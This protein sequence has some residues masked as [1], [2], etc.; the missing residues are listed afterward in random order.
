MS[1]R[2]EEYRALRETIATR[3]T[4]RMVLVPAA[5]FGWALL[6][7]GL[8]VFAR[9]PLLSVLSLLALAAAFE[10]VHALHVGVERIG[11]FIQVFYE[12][13]SAGPR[14]ESTAMRLGPGLPGSG[15]DPLFTLL[16]VGAICAN[17]LVVF[18]PSPSVAQ[19]TLLLL[20]HGAIGGR[21]VRARLAAGRQ[22]TR[23][24]EIFRRVRESEG[25]PSAGPTV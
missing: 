24:L 12:G 23:D 3:G 17:L 13:E 10:A 8:V 9:R 6:A 1:L 11:R 4:C 15:V 14:W 18:I 25:G 20:L 19:A 2:D 5:L 21:V 16:F 7:G 22:R